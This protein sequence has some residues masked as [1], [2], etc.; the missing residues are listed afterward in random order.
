MPVINNR[1]IIIVFCIIAIFSICTYLS[2]NVFNN[3]IQVGKKVDTKEKLYSDVYRYISSI[4]RNLINT[5]LMFNDNTKLLNNDQKL[6]IVINEILND[7]EKYKLDI[8]ELDN[9]FIYKEDGTEYYSLGYV[10]KSLIKKLSYQY[11][12][13][14]D[15]DISS[16]KYY[17]SNSDMVALVERR[18]EYTDY[19]KSDFIDLQKTEYNKYT[20]IFNYK[21]KM[22]NKV[23]EFNIEYYINTRYDE[24]NELNIG[25]E[26]FNI[27]NSITY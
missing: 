20:A 2:F 8:K 19:D 26:G 17:D 4:D 16:Y 25:I 15:I 10:N 18:A 7:L 14:Y 21:R 13:D 6:D 3:F 27:T 22:L 1:K 24:N 12:N 5:S 23:N 9:Q 11:F